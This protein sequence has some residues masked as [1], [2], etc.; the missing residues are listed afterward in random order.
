MLLSF[1]VS[2]AATTKFRKQKISKQK[3]L[4]E[5]VKSIRTGRCSSI[6]IRVIADLLSTLHMVTSAPHS[7]TRLQRQTNPSDSPFFMLKK[8]RMSQ[9]GVCSVRYLGMSLCVGSSTCAE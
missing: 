7:F 1:Y 4:I 6:R 5:G 9:N 8:F 3:G 2:I